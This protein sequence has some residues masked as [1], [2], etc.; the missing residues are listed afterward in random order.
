MV[1]NILNP[2]R[3]RGFSNY[4]ANYLAE[5]E[6]LKRILALLERPG[7]FTL[8]GSR[9]ISLAGPHSDYDYF[10]SD[11][12]MPKLHE[13]LTELGF[14]K[15]MVP[16]P[17]YAVSD[18]KEF[19]YAVS[20]DKEFVAIYEYLDLID[21]LVVKESEYLARYFTQKK[22]EELMN[23]LPLPIVLNFT[24]GEH[25]GIWEKL[26]RDQKKRI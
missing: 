20:D 26:L 3:Q 8:T 4:V 5:S 19:S 12:W 6:H 23:S 2:D 15:K 14:T 18:D 16:P 22:W 13:E 25:R 17:F 21:I 24:I 1:L 10:V 7:L 11:L 9:S